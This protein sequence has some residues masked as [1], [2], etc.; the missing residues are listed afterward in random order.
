M[1]KKEMLPLIC[2]LLVGITLSG[3]ALAVTKELLGDKV[4]KH[5]DDKDP[6]AF[7]YESNNFSKDVK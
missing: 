1:L 3:C 7:A 5:E 2:T 4:A 6:K